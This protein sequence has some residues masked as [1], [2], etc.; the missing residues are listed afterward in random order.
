MINKLF[1]LSFITVSVVA[2][3]SIIAFI[4]I[5]K[6]IDEAHDHTYFYE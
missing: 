3:L 6:A 5:V 2:G 4:S 1:A